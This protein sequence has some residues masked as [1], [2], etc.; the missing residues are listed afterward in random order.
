MTESEFYNIELGT[1]IINNQDNIIVEAISEFEPVKET[2]TTK[3]EPFTIA[4]RNAITEQGY[5]E[6]GVGFITI[7]DIEKWD[8]YR[9]PNTI[10]NSNFR[11]YILERELRIYK[12]LFHSYINVREQNILFLV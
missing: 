9:G 6:E 1:I 12:N 8:I 4:T 3:K 7:A 2:D 10:T 11:M 5:I